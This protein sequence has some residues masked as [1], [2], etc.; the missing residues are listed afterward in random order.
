MEGHAGPDQAE[1]ADRPR[2]LRRG[3]QRLAEGRRPRYQD[4]RV[5]DAE[6]NEVQSAV[7]FIAAFAHGLY[8]WSQRPENVGDF[9][10]RRLGRSRRS[11][12][13]SRLRSRSPG[14]CRRASR[15]RSRSTSASP[16]SPC[17]AP[18][19]SRRARPSA[20]TVRWMDPIAVGNLV[21]VDTGQAPSDGIVFD[22]PSSKKAVVAVI[23]PARGPV[24]RTV[25][26]TALSERA[27]AGENDRALQ[28]LVRRTAPA[29]RGSG[30]RG[31]KTGSARDA[32]GRA[33]AHRPTGR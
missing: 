12:P 17:P 18:A 25:A 14:A 5:L 10:R 13:A 3:P 27:E 15:S 6:G 28:L 29:S 4:V 23:D 1:P 20:S 11:S 21:T 26:R 9:E 7:R 2:A 24:L 31:A 22:L 8:P 32:H 33:S 30:P 19:A 16:R